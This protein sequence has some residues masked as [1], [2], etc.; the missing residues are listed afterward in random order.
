MVPRRR[1]VL[2]AGCLEGIGQVADRPVARQQ[3]CERG[4]TW[5]DDRDRPR[6][7]EQADLGPSDVPELACF[8]RHLGCEVDGRD[9]APDR[10]WHLEVLADDRVVVE[11]DHR[12]WFVC[13]EM[14]VLPTRILPPDVERLVVVGAEGQ[15]GQLEPEAGAGQAVG[16][17]LGVLAMTALGVGP[18]LGRQMFGDLGVP[19]R[20]GVLAV[21]H[22]VERGVPARIAGD[23]A[24]QTEHD[25][26][27]A[28]EEEVPVGGDRVPLQAP[29]L[30]PVRG[31]AGHV[32]AAPM[33]G[34]D[35]RTVF[36]GVVGPVWVVSD[37]G[38]PVLGCPPPGVA[39]DEF[40]EDL[41]V[42]L[43]PGR[44]A[45]RHER[46]RIGRVDEVEAVVA[47]HGGLAEIVPV[48][49]GVPLAFP[50]VSRCRLAMEVAKPA[51]VAWRQRLEIAHADTTK[52]EA[53][54]AA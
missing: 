32:V 1:V 7:L 11:G 16:P 34:R 12:R 15:I 17:D 41:L 47:E 28:L 24:M 45:V 27:E 52:R 31:P 48:L 30:D 13:I 22:N 23:A 39:E 6:D 43:A 21:A 46:H 3:Q 9:R 26:E 4:E 33:R 37:L 29:G 38:Q 8:F 42:D 25:Q 50:A 54:V 35:E 18:P 40:V 51:D 44:S 14:E 49:V 2:V 5:T 20:V 10:R 53:S 36:L 19:P